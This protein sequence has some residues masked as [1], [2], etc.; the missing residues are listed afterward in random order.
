MIYYRKRKYEFKLKVIDHNI[1]LFGLQFK[2]LCT[3]LQPHMHYDNHYQLH[4][5]DA[6]IY[7]KDMSSKTFWL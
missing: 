5:K 1:K 4:L 2:R 6:Y 7:V 3:F